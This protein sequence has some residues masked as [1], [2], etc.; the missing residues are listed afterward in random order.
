MSRGGEIE[1]E[2]LWKG[3]TAAAYL[4]QDEDE[5]DVWLPKSQVEVEASGSLHHVCT[6]LVP[7]W[8]AIEKELV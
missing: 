8:L 7:E 5:R 2:L 4:V 3:E 1:L 6:F